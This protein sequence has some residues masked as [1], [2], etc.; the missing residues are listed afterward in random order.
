MPILGPS[1]PAASFA[2]LLPAPKEANP[3]TFQHITG[4]TCKRDQDLDMDVKIA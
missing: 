4:T 2:Y 3:A 1:C